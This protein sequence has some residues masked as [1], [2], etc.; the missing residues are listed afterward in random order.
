MKIGIIGAGLTGLTAAR[1]LAGAGHQVTV[2][3][4]AAEAGGLAAT[5]PY[6]GTRLEF[7][8]HHYFIS[9]RETV[10]LLRELG[11]QDRMVWRATPMGVFKNNRV[12]GFS[13]PLDLL[14]F[15]PLSFINRLRF[16]LVIL[17][18]SWKKN[19]KKYE[20]LRARQWLQRAFGKQAWDIIWGPLLHGKFHDY[21]PQI[22]MPWF[23]A[24]VHTRAQSREKGMTEERL[25]YL[26]GSFQVLH[27]TLVQEIKA[28]GGTVRFQEPVQK[29]LTVRG[30]LA[31]WKTSRKEEYFD[32]ILATVAPPV[33]L[34]LLPQE[35][36][37]G[38]Y[39][40]KL[41]RVQYLGNVC[42]VLTLRRSLSPVYWMNIPEVDSPFIAVIEHTNFILPEH[43][44]GKHV[45]YLSSYVPATHPRYT[46]KEKDLL[47]AHYAYL[48][49]I[50]PDFT[51]A[52]VEEAR[53][54]HAPF[55]QPVIMAGY[56]ETLVPHA[57]PLPGLF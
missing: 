8:Y 2:C 12:L 15:T 57:S 47:A 30:R 33:L 55:A 25:G 34:P 19:W 22:G 37:Q 54:F 7:F 1:L 14:K 43:Y 27:D 28:G 11:L 21:A 48:Q 51:P 41:R 9:D 42:A 17:Y 32:G 6:Q 44:Q 49:K 52:D 3:E 56:G 39:W 46:A 53:V 45:L 24:R 23:Y 4:A 5:F 50:I 13:T 35:A 40:D 18:L 29:I 31:G 26:Q 10:A 16:G 36:S 20:H 38:P